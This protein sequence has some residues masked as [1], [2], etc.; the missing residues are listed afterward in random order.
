MWDTE[1]QPDGDL[2]NGHSDGEVIEESLAPVNRPDPCAPGA[3]PGNMAVGR[4][5]T[6][7]QSLANNPPSMALDGLSET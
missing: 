7:S 3:V 2:W 6:A 1:T 5:A 4:P